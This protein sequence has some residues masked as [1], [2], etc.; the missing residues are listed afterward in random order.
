MRFS[1]SLS[2]DVSI[3][4]N[5]QGHG[6][7]LFAPRRRGKEGGTMPLHILVTWATRSGSTEEAA[8]LVAQTLRENG[9]SVT[10]KTVDAVGPLLDFDALALGITLYML[11]FHRSARRFLARFREYLTFRATALFV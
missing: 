2:P 3:D 5:M 1:V 10:E 7:P 11:R 8:R 9:L 4:E 6:S